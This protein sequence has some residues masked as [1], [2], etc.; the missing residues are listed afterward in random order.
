MGRRSR[1]RSPKRKESKKHHHSSSDDEAARKDRKA[2]KSDRKEKNV[3]PT[4]SGVETRSKYWRLNA[5]N[6]Y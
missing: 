2:K 6:I 3:T 5:L 1:S 4:K